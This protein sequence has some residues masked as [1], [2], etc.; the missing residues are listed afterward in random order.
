MALLE[1]V[2]LSKHFGGLAA[3]DDVSFEVGEG[4]RIGLIG[5]N[6]A[7]KTTLFN[8]ITGALPEDRGKV[9]FKGK[10][11]TKMKPHQVTLEGIC[12]TFQLTGYFHGMTVTENIKIATLAR[13]RGADPDTKTKEIVELLDL[14]EY[15]D[16]FPGQLS[17]GD[18]KRVEI[19]RALATSPEL[20]LLDEPFSGLSISEIRDLV[21][22]LEVV[23]A[24]GVTLLIIE[25]ILRELMPLVDRV[26]VLNFGKKIAEGSPASVVRNEEVIEAYLGREEHYAA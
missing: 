15:E 9:I 14:G 11:I 5:P 1:A 2:N 6:G 4:E 13:A 23:R 24:Q 3:I 16:F 7:G 19:G 21:Q 22:R 18:L 20:L 25:H 17:Y 26:I 8:L 12:R 10:D